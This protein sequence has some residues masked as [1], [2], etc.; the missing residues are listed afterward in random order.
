MVPDCH[1]DKDQFLLL[2]TKVLS[3]NALPEEEVLLQDTLANDAELRSLYEQYKRYWTHQATSQPA[4]VENALAGVW[5]TI[6]SSTAVPAYPVAAS[7]RKLFYIK[8]IAVAAVLSGLVLMAWWLLGPRR[9]PRV[10]IVETY[11]PKGIRSS[12]VLPDGSK[13]WLAADSRLKYP[14][15]FTPATRELYLEGEA[16]FEVTRNPQKPFV[17]HLKEGAVKVLGTSFDIKAYDENREVITSVAT[18]KVAFI[19]PHATAIDTVF[20][21]PG[22]KSVYN[23]GTG[24][25]LVKETDALAD[26]AWIDGVLLFDVETLGNIAI[27]L[28]RY[29]G[30]TV[31][32]TNE[33]LKRYRYT[34]K[35]ANNT[36]AE[37]LH[38]LS[39]TKEFKYTVSDSLIVIGQ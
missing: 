26:K 37:I 3:G 36:P 19:P 39:K 1:M 29:Y 8:R 13:V 38:F 6:N 31:V 28:E 15:T 17:V 9:E 12:I 23:A 5:N 4:D 20:L 24:T 21:T 34:G 35:F 2:A 33:R 18:G 22:K 11:N 27:A 30:K 10:E 32:F 7:A 16:F 25:T 14:K